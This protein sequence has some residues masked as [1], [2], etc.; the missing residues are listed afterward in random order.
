[1]IFK[2]FRLQMSQH[3]KPI[4]MI[5]FDTTLKLGVFS[6]PNTVSESYLSAVSTLKYYYNFIKENLS[7]VQIFHSY[8]IYSTLLNFNKM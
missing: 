5:L 3:L 2:Y 8:I 6:I 7:S 4:V 1:M